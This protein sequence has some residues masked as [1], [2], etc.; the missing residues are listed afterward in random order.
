MRQ[1]GDFAVAA[2][3]DE[4]WH[5][6]IGE[7]AVGE[8]GGGALDEVVDVAGGLAGLRA[9]AP[10][11]ST[12]SGDGKRA[13]EKDDDA[14]RLHRFEGVKKNLER[15]KGFDDGAVVD[16]VAAGAAIS[17]SGF[18]DG[19]EGEGSTEKRLAHLNSVGDFSCR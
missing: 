16:S 15:R 19:L 10:G 2:R 14:R 9:A 17:E 13:A 7:D 6:S 12:R 3:D 8:D 18:A 5:E 11:L 1:V 4:I